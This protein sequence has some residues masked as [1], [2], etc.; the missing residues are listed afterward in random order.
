MSYISKSNVL[1][2]LRSLFIWELKGGRIMSSKIKATEEF[3]KAKLEESPYFKIDEAAKTYRLEHSYRVA[4]IG[5]KIAEREGF[6][7]EAF[8]IGCLLHDVSYCL[9]YKEDGDWKNHGRYSSKIARPFLESIGVETELIEEICYGIAIHVDDQA[10]FQGERT[11]F[12]VSIGDADNIDRFDAYR[13]YENL[14]NMDFH[15]MTWEEKM[16]KVTSIL[17]RLNKYR[18]LN[19]GTIT[20]TEMWKEKVDFQIEFFNN[21]KEQLNSSKDINL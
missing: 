4:N 12:A 11:P 9:E 20:A 13:I 2:F 7:V 19:F 8:V 17:D 18:S 10:D 3:L 15:K 6:N 21:L 5:K 14:K 16:E 1:E